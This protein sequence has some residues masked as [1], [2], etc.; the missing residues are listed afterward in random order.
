MEQDMID[1]LTTLSKFAD[2]GIVTGS[3]LPYIEEQCGV[4]WQEEHTDI[5]KKKFHI[6]PCNGTQR[7]TFR[8]EKL[9]LMSCQNMRD[10]SKERYDALIRCILKLQADIVH[11][12][13]ELP[14]T[15]NFVSYRKSLVNWCPIGREADSSI[16]EQF[17]AL[18]KKLRIRETL[19]GL[20]KMSIRKERVFD[21]T[22]AL[23]G[24]TSIDI[25]PDGWDKS[26]ALSH[27]THRNIWFVGDKCFGDGNDSH[28]YNALASTGHAFSTENPQNTIEIIKEKI[29]PRLS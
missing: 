9:H 7:Y 18:D 11:M 26:Y 12:M 16:R 2:I 6:L 27:Y 5:P 3:G 21:M 10:L 23:G 25:Y 4:L 20:L 1:T 17:I 22:L 8:N 28:I 15:G 29:I 19:L 13:P 24:E 14:L